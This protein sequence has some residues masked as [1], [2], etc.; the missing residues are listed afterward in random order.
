MK[1]KNVGIKT[2]LGI[3]HFSKWKIIGI[4]S[5]CLL[6]IVLSLPNFVDSNRLPSFL[7]RNKINYGLDLRGGVQLLM[8]VDFDSY[9][10]EQMDITS[11]FVRKALRKKRIMYTGLKADG[12]RIFFNLKNVNNA[13][14]VK[15]ILFK[16][17]RGLEIEFELGR[18]KI[19]Y[20]AERYERLRSDLIDQTIEIIR[21]R[22]DETGT[23]D[24]SIQRQGDFGI[25]LQAPGV[26]DPTHLKRVLGR[27]AKLTFH[28]VDEEASIEQ[29]LKGIV[30]PRDKLLPGEESKGMWYVIKDKVVLTGDLLTNAQLST[31][32]GQP[33][34]V[35]SFNTLGAKLFADITSKNTEKR[36][37]IVLDNKVISAPVINGPILA[38]TGSISG[39]F[40]LQSA[41]ELALLLR[42]GALPVPLAIAEEKVVGPSLG[43]DSII[44]GKKSGMI[45]VLAIIVFMVGIYGYLGMFASIA[46]ILNLIFI[47]SI[48]GALQATLTMPGIAGIVLTMGMAVDTNVL[49]FERIKEELKINSTVRYAVKQG[50]NHAFATIL[51]SNLTTLIA[52]F[53]LYMFGSGVIKGF[54]V[55]LTIG[56]LSSMFTAIT[57][58]KLLVYCWINLVSKKC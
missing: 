35:F 32:T 10:H 2:G 53:F 58:T 8:Q 45:A 55:T 29:A 48:M 13:D 56:I 1:R 14:D 34:V 6:L 38:G 3:M 23:L 52:A 33:T 27:T 17:D 49:I 11:D 39:N 12:G 51:D 43:E 7:S 30:P 47:L 25:L 44:F 24:P 41:S 26:Y 46:T 18:A 22:I 4:L 19:S 15:K 42:A 16:I 40:T 54:A 5:F 31:D 50:F 21:R 37:A 20:P 57:V 9:V 28:L 36:L